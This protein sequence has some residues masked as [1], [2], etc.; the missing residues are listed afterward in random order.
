[1][2]TETNKA[3]IM[4]A[5][6]ELYKAFETLDFKKAANYLTSDCDYITFNGMHVQGREAYIQLHEEMMDNFM[7]RGA[8][9]EA[10]VKTIRFLNE[11]TAVVIATGAI[12]FRWQKKAP[13]NRQ[14]IN[15]SIWVK[16]TEG[17]WQLTAFHNCRVREI[18][19]FARW[20]LQLKKKKKSITP[21][22][23]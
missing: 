4:Q 22:L 5:N 23:G 20:I 18:P 12:R 16:S 3:A 19:R 6:D 1:M 2:I 21:A 10:S 7:F 13:K 14:S 15:T 9:L 11:T 8:R 17:S